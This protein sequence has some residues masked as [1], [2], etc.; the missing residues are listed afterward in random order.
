MIV[1]PSSWQGGEEENGGEEAPGPLAGRGVW[2]FWLY[3][4]LVFLILITYF[5]NFELQFENISYYL[6]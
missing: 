3:Q 1:G 5:N 6:Y 4:C 2:E